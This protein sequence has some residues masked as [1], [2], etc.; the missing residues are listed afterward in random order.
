MEHDRL[1]Q[2]SFMVDLV[3][4]NRNCE[5]VA[6]FSSMGSCAMVLSQAALAI[7]TKHVGS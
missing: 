1:F 2:L 5:R 3:L 6:A 4:L 7:Y